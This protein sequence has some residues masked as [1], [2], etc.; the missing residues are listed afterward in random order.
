MDNKKEKTYWAAGEP[1][2]DGDGFVGIYGAPGLS[3]GMIRDQDGNI[4]KFPDRDLAELA[5]W[6]R[7]GEVINSLPKLA[8]RHGG[9]QERYRKPT[10]PEFANLMA[11]AAVTPTAVAYIVAQKLSKIQ[12]WVSGI[13]EKGNAT[14]APHWT[15]VLL[16]IF[17]KFPESFDFALELT[18]K[19]TIDRRPAEA[20]S[21]PSADTMN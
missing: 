11:D 10:G 21:K 2:R 14:A 5:A 4:T 19:Y 3:A 15:R 16:R 17:A 9:K 13:D 6:R 12:E 18:E 8:S 7:M 20:R 1:A